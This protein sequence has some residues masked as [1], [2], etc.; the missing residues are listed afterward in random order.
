MVRTTRLALLSAALIVVVALATLM[1]PLQ[2][3]FAT[4]NS[5]LQAQQA[6]LQTTTHLSPHYLPISKFHLRGLDGPYHTQGNMILGIDNSPYLF[7]GVARD[8]LEYFCKG[9]AH[10][11]EQELAYMGLGQSAANYTYWG[12]NIV[13][14]PLSENFWLYGSPSQGC[15][16]AQYQS[17]VKKVVDILT[18]LNLNVM[19]DLQWTNAG[20]QAPGAGGSWS[21]TDSDSITFW[22]QVATIYQTYDNVLFEMYNEP[23]L[24]GNSWACWRNGCQITNDATGV[25][26]QDFSH[27]SYQAVGMQKLLDTIRQTGA[28]NLVIAAG[29]NWGYD[30]S[31]MPIYHLD[32]LNVVY[33]THPYPYGYKTSSYWD[34]AFGN[35]SAIYPVISAESGENDCGTSYESQLINYFDAHNIGWI[36]WAWVVASGDPCHYPEVI[37][38][39][40]GTPLPGMGQ[41]EQQRFM[42]YIKTLYNE[43]IPELRA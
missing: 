1:G 42:G 27:Y 33:D 26:P 9:D 38:D 13:R 35:I 39:Y 41:M 36:G 6:Q 40:N 16:P 14:L 5:L 28:N 15:S 30:L 29:L 8:D 43:E 21:M 23:H 11:T 24:V 32:G 34:N 4:S 2:T 12:V 25:T 37:K 10:Y 20:G 19:L 3:V 18:N 22:Q 31:Q 7:H 17:L